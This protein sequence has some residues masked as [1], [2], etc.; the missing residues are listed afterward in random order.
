MTNFSRTFIDKTRFQ[1]SQ[2]VGD[3]G[4]IKIN[5]TGCSFP[6]RIICVVECANENLSVPLLKIYIVFK[7]EINFYNFFLSESR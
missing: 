3:P 7:T 6:E 5:F 4:Q 2:G 1:V